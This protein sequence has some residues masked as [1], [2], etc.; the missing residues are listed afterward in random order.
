MDTHSRDPTLSKYF[1]SL[2]LFQV[3]EINIGISSK[4]HTYSLMMHEKL[5]SKG[6]QSLYTFINSEE[7]N[8]KVK[9]EKVTNEFKNYIQT[10][11]TSADSGKNMCK[12]SKK[13][14]IKLY[15]ELQLQGIHCLYI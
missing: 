10:T 11:C 9:V 5:C 8:D 7:D 4:A 13:T 15:E 12:V 6:T 14:G 3:K 2:L 1:A